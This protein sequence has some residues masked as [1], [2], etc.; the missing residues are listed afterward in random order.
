MAMQLAPAAGGPAANFQLGRGAAVGIDGP[1]PSNRRAGAQWNSSPVFSPLGSAVLELVLALVV[2][3][4]QQ[5]DHRP[6][7]DRLALVP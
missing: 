3:M 1:A 6:A 5:L 4:A 2:P 7:R